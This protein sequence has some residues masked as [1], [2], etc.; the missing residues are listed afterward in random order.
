VALFLGKQVPV[1]TV[2]QAC[3]DIIK[4]YESF[5]PVAYRDDAGVW[6]IG[7]GTTRVNGRPVQRG[8]TCTHDQAV[9]WMTTH[10]NASVPDV[11]K[12]CHPYRPVQHELDALVDFVYNLGIGNFASSSL[13]KNLRTRR[14]VTESNFLRWNKA[15]DPK[16]NLLVE[17][18]GLTRRRRTEYTL[19]TTNVVN[20][21]EGE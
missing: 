12:V 14:P 9:Q 5:V 19:F 10:V 6:T 4:H 8:M 2:S 16:T 7:Y 18:R 13:A 17:L 11:L 15:R 20:F 1:M 21:Y 3:I